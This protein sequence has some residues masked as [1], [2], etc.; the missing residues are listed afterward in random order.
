[1]FMLNLLQ[2]QAKVLLLSRIAHKLKSKNLGRLANFRYGNSTGKQETRKKAAC[3]IWI[4][5]TKYEAYCK[6]YEVHVEPDSPTFDCVFCNQH[7][8]WWK[9]PE[10][11]SCIE[12]LYTK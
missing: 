11:H 1:M 9:Q 3:E 7:V 12:I 5:R 2:I 6:K 10:E 8:H 4:Y